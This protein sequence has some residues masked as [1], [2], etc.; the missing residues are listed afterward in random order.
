VNA[1]NQTGARGAPKR[2]D[3]PAYASN[4]RRLRS[5]S[6]ATIEACLAMTPPSVVVKRN[7]RTGRITSAQFMPLP[8]DS[9]AV[10]GKEQIRKHAHMGQRYCFRQKVDDEGHQAW[11]F[12]PFLTPL[13][14]RLDPGVTADD[15]ERWLQ[16][17]FRAVPLSCLSAGDEEKA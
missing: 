8:R 10:E 12:A 16:S 13:A 11:R 9:S 7:K 2:A 15:I 6:L 14:M 4:G 1:S 5:Y 17:I 3:I